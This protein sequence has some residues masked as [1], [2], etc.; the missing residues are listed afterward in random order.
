VLAWQKKVGLT[1]G[2]KA[3][4]RRRVACFKVRED[5]DD[6]DKNPLDS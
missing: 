4:E 1:E 3:D 6:G 2:R 5:D